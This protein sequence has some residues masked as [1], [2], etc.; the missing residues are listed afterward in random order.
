MNAPVENARRINRTWLVQGSLAQNA[1]AYLDLL[2]TRHS[3]DLEDVCTRAIAAARHASAE[4]RD[5]K[6]DFY[7][8]LFSR[9]T[10]EER[11][12]FLRDHAWTY[13]RSAE[14]R[15]AGSDRCENGRRQAGLREGS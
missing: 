10:D 15:D 6:P 2:D 5:P 13:R 8:T 14:L 3:S 12:R 7:A 11:D 1:A 4:G 9:A